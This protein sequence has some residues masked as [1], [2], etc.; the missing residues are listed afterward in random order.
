MAIGKQT[1]FVVRMTGNE[2]NLHWQNAGFLTCMWYIQVQ[3]CSSY[4]RKL[5]SSINQ[6]C[7]AV[8]EQVHFYF[9]MQYV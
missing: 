7:E 9:Q 8:Y 3:L 1:S 5:S 4:S 6:F 2:K